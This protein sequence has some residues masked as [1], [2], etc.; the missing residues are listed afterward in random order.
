[1]ENC[2]FEE[3]VQK[4]KEYEYAGFCGKIAPPA[5][6]FPIDLMDYIRM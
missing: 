3:L 6:S 4:I 5:L 1:L 2:L